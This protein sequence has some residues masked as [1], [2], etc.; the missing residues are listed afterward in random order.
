MALEAC[1]RML[2]SGRAALEDA[3]LAR[4]GALLLPGEIAG[5]L[6]PE[7][8]LLISPHGPLHDIPWAAL[9]GPGV[10]PL[11][12]CA[13]PMVTSS[14]EAW[15]LLAGRPAAF[16]LTGLALAV[17]EFRR[18]FPALPQA[19]AEAQFLGSQSGLR[20]TSLADEQATPGAFAAALAG[21]APGFL[22]VATHL[23]VDREGGRLS[24]MAFPEGVLLLDELLDLPA[25]PPLVVL[26]GCNGTRAVTFPGDERLDFTSAFLLNGARQV[27]GSLWK[28]ADESAPALMEQFYPALAAGAPAHAA[29]AEAQRRLA[30]SGAPDRA[31][32]GFQCVGA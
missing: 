29:L 11:A 12:Q 10:G 31:W 28:V 22:H 32:A 2:T 6:E 21:E 19:R 3:D 1:Q 25:A 15:L 30:A 24:G 16:R 8:T 4:L 7:V 23:F 9:R 14:L 18:G 17:S 27:V 5:R 20:V 13:R 26:S